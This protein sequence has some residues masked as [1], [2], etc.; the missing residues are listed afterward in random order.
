MRRTVRTNNS[1]PYRALCKGPC[2]AHVLTRV[3]SS[4]GAIWM[5]LAGDGLTRVRTRRNRMRDGGLPA[6]VEDAGGLG[7]SAGAR[8]GTRRASRPLARG[9]IQ[10]LLLTKRQLRCVRALNAGKISIGC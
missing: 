2:A 6:D 4:R 8:V 3:G 1:E 10:A 7:L 9:I 5:N